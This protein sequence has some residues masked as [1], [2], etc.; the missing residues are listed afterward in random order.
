MTDW[1]L[2]WTFLIMYNKFGQE[3]NYI[4]RDLVQGITIY[5][6]ISSISWTELQSESSNLVKL[7]FILPC[8]PSEVAPWLPYLCIASYLWLLFLITMVSRKFQGVHATSCQHRYWVTQSPQ[9]RWEEIKLHSVF[10]FVGVWTSVNYPWIFNIL[11]LWLNYDPQA[12]FLLVLRDLNTNK[13]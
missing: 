4:Y 3:A 12:T 13:S 5:L 9:D 6:V 1:H 2:N 10:A 7:H 11:I 8:W